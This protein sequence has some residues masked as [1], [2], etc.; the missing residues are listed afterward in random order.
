[1]PL[2]PSKWEIIHPKVNKIQLRYDEYKVVEVKGDGNCLTNC[3]QCLFEKTKTTLVATPTILELKLRMTLQVFLRLVRGSSIIAS[4]TPP[5]ADAVAKFLGDYGNSP[6]KDDWQRI[7]AQFD[8]PKKTQM[9]YKPNERHFMA[10]LNRI[11]KAYNKGN[12][13]KL[14]V[15]YESIFKPF[16]LKDGYS[17]P[18][19]ALYFFCE[20]FSYNISLWYPDENNPGSYFKMEEHGLE[21]QT[22]FMLRQGQFR[23]GITKESGLL[24]WSEDVNNISSPHF[25][26]LFLKKDGVFEL[27]DD[28]DNVLCTATLSS[29]YELVKSNA[30]MNSISVLKGRK[31]GEITFLPILRHRFVDFYKLY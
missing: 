9:S 21:H 31:R 20:A 12:N 8:G 22:T 17:L 13:P 3:I 23:L 1:M 19:E 28:K 14:N 26:V 29:S 16:I 25:D 5:F 15:L 11:A 27:L 4:V 18:S 24:K 10:D 2:L 30:E 6:V 7:I